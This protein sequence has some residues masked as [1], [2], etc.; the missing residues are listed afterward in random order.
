MALRL[1]GRFP[2]K[3]LVAQD[4]QTPQVHL[5]VVH[6]TLD[7]LRRQVVQRPTQRRASKNKFVR[8]SQNLRGK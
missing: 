4:A 5:L 7:H 3:E 2:D 8:K 1:E 6:L